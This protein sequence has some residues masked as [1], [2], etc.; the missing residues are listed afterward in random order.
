LA[1]PEE[2]TF[3]YRDNNTENSNG[4]NRTRICDYDKNVN[5]FRVHYIR[6]RA[7]IHQQ[8]AVC[9][10][11]GCFPGDDL[12]Q[13]DLPEKQ[14]TESNTVI[15]PGNPGIYDLGDVHAEHS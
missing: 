9:G 10:E 15:F 14:G 8:N 13:P 1:F 7:S 3:L 12:H 2:K 4:Q 5:N 6:L 11:Y